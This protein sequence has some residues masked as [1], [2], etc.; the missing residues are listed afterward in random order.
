MDGSSGTS[1]C[2]PSV[3]YFHR[4]SPQAVLTPTLSDAQTPVG[5]KHHI[6]IQD[7]KREREKKK[8]TTMQQRIILLDLPFSDSVQIIY[9]YSRLSSQGWLPYRTSS[10]KIMYERI[11]VTLCELFPKNNVPVVS[12]ETHSSSTLYRNKINDQ[13]IWSFIAILHIRPLF[14]HLNTL[15]HFLTA[16]SIAQ[17]YSAG[18]ECGRSRV[19]SPVKDRVIPETL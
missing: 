16:S 4:C 14:Y 3:L 7:S 10:G 18:F 11:R 15:K 2:T 19:Q 9:V 1:V 13:A 5:G 17:W 8:P 6:I 12:K